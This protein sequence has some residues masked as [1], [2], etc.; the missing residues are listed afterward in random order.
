MTEDQILSALDNYK[1]GYYC[2][3]IS[4]GQPYS[5]IIDC[6]LNVFLDGKNWA[7]AAERLG[8][9]PR[10][11]RIVLEIFYFGNCLRNLEHYNGQDTNYYAVY[12]VDDEAFYEATDGESLA[13]D[14]RFWLVRGR[15]VELS[16]NKEHYTAAGIDLKEYEPG[17]IRVEEAARLVILGHR[18]LFRAT[19]AEL[20]KSL[21]RNLM[22]ILVLDQWYHRD[23]T[24]IDQPEISDDQLMKRFSQSQPVMDFDSFVQ[25]NRT[26][27]QSNESYNQAQWQNNR[28][29][30]YETWQ[31]LATVIAT[32]DPSAYQPTL[33]PN[34]HWK[35]W[36]DSGSL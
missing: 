19:D 27:Q 9:N 13:E 22:K 2:H 28:P 33:A 4:L 5:Y 11:G 16:H 7:I 23:F 26:Q 1:W 25:L 24:E 17:A 30:A 18:D 36:P 32:G 29:S 31:L 10:A 35:L 34:T 12:P 21:P 6:R 20:Y 14:G 8:Y 15:E 3:F